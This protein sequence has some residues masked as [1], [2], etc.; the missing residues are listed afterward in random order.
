[1]KL[2][3]NESSFPTGVKKLP[4]PKDASDEGGWPKH[5]STALGRLLRD[6]GWHGGPRFRISE[7]RN[8]SQIAKVNDAVNW[9]L[10]PSA[11]RGVAMSRKYNMPR[12]SEAEP[13]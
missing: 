13:R 12:R 7:S 1:M 9:C 10:Q 8:P 6:G 3:V 4:L 2:V 11:N 5:D